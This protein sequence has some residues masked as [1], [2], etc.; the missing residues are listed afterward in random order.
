MEAPLGRLL[1]VAHKR[2]HSHIDQALAGVDLS[3]A[4]YLVLRHVEMHPGMTQRELAHRL[5]I[6]GPTLTHHLDRLADE[7]LV[8]RVRGV[9]DRRTS[10]TVLTAAG[11]SH[12]RRA[13]KVADR[14]NTEL[15]SLF[16]PGELETFEAC[17]QRLADHYTRSDDDDH[18][19]SGR[20]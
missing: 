1:A 7:G 18:H 17:L 14:V 9:F 2:V 10:S 16:S 6:E 15:R 13:A 12:V 20:V 11:E 3:L 8:E 19:A 5:G 4:T